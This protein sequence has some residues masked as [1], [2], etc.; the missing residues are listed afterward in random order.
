MNSKPY[1]V[2]NEVVGAFGKQLWNGTWSSGYITVPNTDK[3]IAFMLDINNSPAIAFR[4]GDEVHGYSILGTPD[5]PA[6]YIK[7]F[8]ASVSGDTW[9]LTAMK[10]TN[11]HT[12]DPWHYTSPS[13]MVV[14]SITGLIPN[15]GA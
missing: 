6:Q 1:E 11:H 13:S 15:W 2:M 14:N 7:F 3:Y 5:S 10:Q 4:L 8:R 12:A 9:T